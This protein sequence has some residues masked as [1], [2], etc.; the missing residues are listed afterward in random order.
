MKLQAQVGDETHDVEIRRDGG[1]VFAR[2]DDREYELEASE[3]EPNVYLLKHEGRVHEFFVS[4]R[5][6]TSQLK[7]AMRHFTE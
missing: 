1:R 2:V 6:I 4:C 7:I 5:I 3:P